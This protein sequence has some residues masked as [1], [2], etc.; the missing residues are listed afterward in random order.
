MIVNQNSPSAHNG[1]VAKAQLLFTSAEE[2]C[3]ETVLGEIEKSSFNCLTGKEGQTRLM[4]SRLCD[5]PLE[6]GV[7]NFIVFKEQGMTSLWTILGWVGIRVKFKA[8][9]IFWF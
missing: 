2:K 9:S 8:S 5:P 4:P 6:R 1:V 7:R 3:R